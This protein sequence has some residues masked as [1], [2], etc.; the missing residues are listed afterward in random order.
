[1]KG[2]QI[3]LNSIV[4]VIFIYLLFMYSGCELHDDDYTPCPEEHN[5][6]GVQ[7]CEDNVEKECYETSVDWNNH[8]EVHTHRDCDHYQG[9]VCVAGK[10]SF[11]EVECTIGVYFCRDDFFLFCNPYGNAELYIVCSER[12]STCIE[13]EEF[14]D[15]YDVYCQ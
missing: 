11:P 2:T 10:C 3:V 5:R 7:W 13:G 1:M 12:N 15:S 14:T 8:L 4:K 6:D 9:S